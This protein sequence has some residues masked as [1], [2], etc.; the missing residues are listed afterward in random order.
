[1][2]DS[3]ARLHCCG[4]HHHDTHTPAG[5]DLVLSLEHSSPERKVIAYGTGD[6]EDSAVIFLPSQGLF[7]WDY[8]H[9]RLLAD[10]IARGANIT[11]LIPKLT[12]SKEQGSIVTKVTQGIKRN[13]DAAFSSESETDADLS[14]ANDLASIAE[15]ISHLK[16]KMNVS[17]IGL[18][19]SS[20]SIV[21]QDLTTTTSSTTLRHDLDCAVLISNHSKVE[22][23]SF[24]VPITII[25]FTNEKRDVEVIEDPVLVR[26]TSI[27]SESGAECLN[28]SS[29]PQTHDAMKEIL[30]FFKKHLHD[31]S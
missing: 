1:M 24:M 10:S 31:W 16:Q 26:R 17:F 5:L 14:L 9:T 28:D 30:Y 8:L 23:Q 22:S 15:L 7:E 4:A 27:A 20:D 25:Q 18:L 3:K 19:S 6:N 21:L 13:N 11:V 29:N 2:S 12:N